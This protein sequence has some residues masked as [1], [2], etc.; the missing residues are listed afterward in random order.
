MVSMYMRCGE[1]YDTGV[2]RGVKKIIFMGSHV[3]DFFSHDR[4]PD[5]EDL[6]IVGLKERTLR[7]R[8]SALK[9]LNCSHPSKGE[10]AELN[11]SCPSLIELDCRGNRIEVLRIASCTLKTL[12][13]GSN[14]MREVRLDCPKLV[15]FDC[16][17]NS[18]QEIVLVCPELQTANF[19][20]NWL[21][22]IVLD[23]C[24]LGQLYLG[25]NPD[26]HL[27]SIQLHSGTTPSISY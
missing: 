4:F 23:C 6:E 5:M 11:L 20:S 21:R 22:K 1:N 14:W 9:K 25:Q 13:C 8:A 19:Y 7:I 3:G 10:I 24:R 27:A 26:L 18:I 15:H 2:H 17:Y 12:H 16:A